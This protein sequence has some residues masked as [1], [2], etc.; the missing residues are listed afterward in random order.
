MLTIGLSLDDYI[1]RSQWVVTKAY[2]IVEK[3]L[4]EI[5]IGMEIIIMPLK[6]FH[7]YER[8][9]Y[10]DQI[11]SKWKKNTMIKLCVNQYEKKKPTVPER[12]RDIKL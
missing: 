1:R 9:N 6:C 4:D 8:S 12:E 3:Y 7:F 2:K 10:K 5:S 11:N